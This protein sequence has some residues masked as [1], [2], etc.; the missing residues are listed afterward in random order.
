[1][2]PKHPT[3][4]RECKSDALVIEDAKGC[5]IA[6]GY[7]ATSSK[8]IISA[9]NEIGKEFAPKL[10]SE[11]G[12]PSHSDG[13]YFIIWNS[14]CEKPSVWHSD[15]HMPTTCVAWLRLPAL[16]IEDD[17]DKWWNQWPEREQCKESKGFIRAGWEAAKGAK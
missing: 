3:P 1:M 15:Y 8:A 12:L 9:A 11:H 14:N 16:P 10:V 5:P 2:T 13:G 4:W 17:F 6:A 7:A